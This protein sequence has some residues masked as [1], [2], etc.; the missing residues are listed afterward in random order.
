MPDDL[1]RRLAGHFAKQVQDPYQRPQRWALQ[2]YRRMEPTIFAVMAQEAINYCISQGHDWWQACE[3]LT[4]VFKLED[5]RDR[6][7]RMHAG[8]LAL[9][10]V[11][12]GLPD[13]YQLNLERDTQ[14][15]QRIH[16]PQ[17]V[18]GAHVH[19]PPPPEDAHAEPLTT[20]PPPWER[21][22][23]DGYD[24]LTGPRSDSREAIKRAFQDGGIRP[25]ADAV[26]SLQRVALT[27]NP[28]CWK[29]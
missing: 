21:F 27:I 18:P 16:A 26:S 8:N 13:V 2:E 15:E 10:F 9:G 28:R 6:I 22:K 12:E 19:L 3:H 14:D 11:V 20:P 1:T 5:G 29:R 25:H 23:V 4:R 24:F 7:E 17:L